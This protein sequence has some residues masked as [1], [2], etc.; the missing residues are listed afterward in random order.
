MAICTAGIY[1]ISQS[2]LALKHRMTIF[3]IALVTYPESAFVDVSLE[4][5]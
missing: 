2:P 4:L 5:I 1:S 3:D